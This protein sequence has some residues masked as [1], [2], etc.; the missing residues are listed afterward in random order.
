MTLRHHSQSVGQNYCVYVGANS[1]LVMEACDVSSGSG[2]GVGVEGGILQLK[3]S[4][5]HDCMRH[6]VA[7]YGGFE[8]APG[9]CLVMGCTIRS[10]RLSGVFVRDGGSAVLRDNAVLDNGEYGVAL[11]DGC[12]AR[13]F[14]NK[15]AGNGTG[16]VQVDVG[17]V[18]V[19]VG[20]V[21]GKNSLDRP[22]TAIRL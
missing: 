21:N 5:V 3:D 4:S 8:G 14:D 16:S 12:T 15:V 19:D 10:N 13:L 17:S 11:L 20:E 7:A 1:S 6:G 9:R 22:A 2:N 18:A